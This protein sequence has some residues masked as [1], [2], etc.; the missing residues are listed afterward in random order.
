ML[1]FVK[2]R[3]DMDKL[4]DLGQKLLNNELDLSNILSTY[5]LQDDPSVGISIWQSENRKEFDRAFAPHKEFYS[6][7][8]EVT[9][10]ITPEESQK[11]LMKKL[12]QK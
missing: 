5:C 12:A 2:V 11:I 6:E 8:I 9:P 7:V 1:F 3:I 4:G 10:V